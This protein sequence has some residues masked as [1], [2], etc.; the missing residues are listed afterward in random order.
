MREDLDY[1]GVCVM[2]GLAGRT[3]LIIE[4]EQLVA[5]D[6]CEALEKA[7]GQVQVAA[8][9]T[10]AV[11]EMCPDVAAAVLDFTL[12][13]GDARSLCEELRSR[14]IPFVV[15]SGY[16]RPAILDVPFIEK[17]ARPAARRGN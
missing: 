14:N 15:Y 1:C 11:Q 4:D 9:R 7:G 8:T 16:P 17:P 13:D 3:I 12:H 2:S 5:L 10:A 6:I